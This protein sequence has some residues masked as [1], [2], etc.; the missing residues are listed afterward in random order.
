MQWRCRAPQVFAV[1][2]ERVPSGGWR[3]VEFTERLIKTVTE[4]RSD[5]DDELKAVRRGAGLRTSV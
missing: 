4:Y 5:L 2:I 3:S 1:L